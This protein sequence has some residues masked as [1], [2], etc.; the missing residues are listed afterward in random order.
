MRK[1]LYQLLLACMFIALGA[2]AQT[3]HEAIVPQGEKEGSVERPFVS[4]QQM[5]QFPGGEDAM[6]KFLGD[7]LRY[8][9]KCKKQGISGIV[10]VN[11]IIDQKGNVRNA[12]VK[13]GVKDCEEMNEEALRVV[14]EMPAWEI[15]YQNNEPAS[16]RFTVPVKFILN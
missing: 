8:P 10:Y 2:Q 14:K 16:V 11:F 12:E 15:G 13:R 4:V 9:K 3:N 7:N 5:P 1:Q 6:F